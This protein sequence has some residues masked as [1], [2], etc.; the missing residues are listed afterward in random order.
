M[1]KREVAIFELDVP[2]DIQAISIQKY[3]A[4][5]LPQLPEWALREAFLNRDVKMNGLRVKGDALTLPGAHVL[6]YARA[7]ELPA[8]RLLDIVYEDDNILLL[9]KAPGISVV[10]DSG[11]GLTLTQLAQNYVEENRQ[12]QLSP[13]PCHRLDNQTGGLLLFAKTPM[14]EKIMLKG[15]RDKLI[16][17]KYICLVKGTPSPQEALADAWLCKDAR[18]SRV[19]ITKT[20]V[21]GS[22]FIRTGYRVLNPGAVSRLEIDLVTGRTHQIR[23]HMAYLGHPILGDDAYGDR[24]FNREQRSRQLMLWSTQ[25]TLWAE[26]PLEYLNGKTF[27]IAPPF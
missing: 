8:E 26:S 6:V 5:A 10:E 17:K 16:T 3:V 1:K 20:E 22:M 27:T 19:Q 11:G 25:M 2:M 15:F 4:R 14:A 7:K 21:P 18:K 24:A 13:R 12:G 9:N 23:A